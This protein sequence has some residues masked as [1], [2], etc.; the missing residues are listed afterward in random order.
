LL[1][2]NDLDGIE[3]V[4]TDA[5]FG[6]VSSVRSRPRLGPVFAGSRLIAADAARIAAGLLLELKTSATLTPSMQDNSRSAGR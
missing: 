1:I 4:V 5:V 3:V 2:N 6:L